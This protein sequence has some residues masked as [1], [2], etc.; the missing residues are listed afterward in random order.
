M[1]FEIIQPGAFVQARMERGQISLGKTGQ[2]WLCAEDCEQVSIRDRCVI[3][4]DSG[5]L[6]IGLRAA[7]HGEVEFAA[8]VGIVK[9]RKCRDSGRRCINVARALRQLGLEVEAVRGRYQLAQ[10]DN[11]LI[12]ALCPD[13]TAGAGKAPGGTGRKG[14]R[15][16]G[17]AKQESGERGRTSAAHRVGGCMR[18]E[19]Q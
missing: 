19:P 6:R 11:L 16:R 12:L 15:D 18:G 3:L 5:T 14:E 8:R 4:A 10:K 13:L 17:G 9:G 2:L 7:D 1:G